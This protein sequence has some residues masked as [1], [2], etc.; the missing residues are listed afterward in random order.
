MTASDEPR[1]LDAWQ[2]RRDER[3]LCLAP[4]GELVPRVHEVLAGVGA[5]GRVVAVVRGEAWLSADLSPG[6]EV[7]DDDAGAPRRLPGPFD[8]A[9]V[10]GSLPFVAGLAELLAPLREALRPGG[11]LWLDLPA[12]GWSAVLQACDPRAASWWLPA[13]GEVEETLV[14]HGWRDV[15]V[16][17]WLELDTYTSVAEVLE[18]LSRPF[19]VDFE[20]AAGRRLA[21]TLRLGLARTFGD[22]QVSLARRRVRTFCRR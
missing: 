13:P 20:G 2:P 16:E 12:H 11:R 1:L 15:R 7:V 4:P 18:A 21:E 22:H 19:P 3:V 17:T 5:V 6:I 10:W 9:L 8:L 14:E